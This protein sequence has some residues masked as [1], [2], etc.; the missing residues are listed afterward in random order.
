MRSLFIA[1]VLLISTAAA[2]A[3]PHAE[4]TQAWARATPP[5][6][7]MGVVYLTL[8]SH[9]DD[10][11]VGASTPI[12]TKVEMHESRMSEGVMS[13]HPLTTV[14]IPRGSAVHFEPAGKHFMLI[15]LSKPLQVGET[16]PF[17]LKL[18]KAGTLTVTVN[19]RKA[20]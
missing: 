9:E 10:Q 13:M 18:A 2:Q 5:G 20:E 6:M 8:Q 12:A 7:T 19:V 16:F 15:G 3:E 14:A 1:L 11:L 4:A 17:T